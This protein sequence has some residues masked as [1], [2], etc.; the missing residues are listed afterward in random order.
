MD[1]HRD[2][3][4]RVDEGVAGGNSVSLS[5]AEQ[6]AFSPSRCIRTIGPLGQCR[7]MFLIVFF[8]GGS[9]DR[10]GHIFSTASFPIGKGLSGGGHRR[11]SEYI[12]HTCLMMK[13]VFCIEFRS[14]QRRVCGSP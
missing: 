13:W 9:R 4:E 1:G 10:S 8:C 3:D 7:V 12:K 6:K 14:Q 11:R 5:L 2:D